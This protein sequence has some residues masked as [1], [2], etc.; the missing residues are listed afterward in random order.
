MTHLDFTLCILRLRS[1]FGNF[2]FLNFLL[3]NSIYLLIGFITL[4]HY[5]FYKWKNLFLRMTKSSHFP[6]QIWVR[7]SWWAK[8]MVRSGSSFRRAIIMT[9]DL[10]WEINFRTIWIWLNCQIKLN[11]KLILVNR[12]RRLPGYSWPMRFKRRGSLGIS[13]C[14]FRDMILSRI[15]LSCLLENRKRRLMRLRVKN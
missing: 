8:R 2:S 4:F 12:K 14:L 11:C 15:N 1:F 3:K 6:K 9:L 10:N 5:I 13:I 7:I